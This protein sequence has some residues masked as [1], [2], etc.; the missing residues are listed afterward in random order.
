LQTQDMAPTVEPMPEQSPAAWE[1]IV[2]SRL[3]GCVRDFRVILESQGLV[4]RGTARTFYAK[5]LAQ[6]LV[7]EL[8]DVPIAANEID[9]VDGHSS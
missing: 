3:K 4:L 6:H 7:M 2:K 8:S 1:R 9:V 5:Q